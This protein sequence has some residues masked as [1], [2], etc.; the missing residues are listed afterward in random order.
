MALGL[1]GKLR[2]VAGRTVRYKLLILV[3]FPILLLMPVALGVAAI[4]GARFTYDQLFIKVNTD[5]SVAH[6]VFVRLRQ[7]YLHALERLAESYPFRTALEA[8]DGTS[9]H[10]QV[11]ALHEQRHFSYLHVTDR[12]GQ[13]L[14]EAG[15]SGTTRA[16]PLRLAAVQGKPV[17]GVEIF[18]ARDL[19]MESAG[20]AQAVR[21]PLLPTPRARPSRREEED[22]GMMIRMIYPVRDSVGQVTALLDGGVL[23]NGNFEF[24][25]AIRDL[26][27]GPGSLP[28]GSIGTVTVFLDDV[29]ISTNVPLA[30]GERAL[31]TRVSDEVRTQVL[32][33]GTVWI[34]RAFVVND[35]Y[36]SSY[37]PILDV[38]GERIG[39]LY[40]GF[41]E[42]PFRDTMQRALA[43]LALLF[44]VLM[45]LSS[46]VAVRGAKSIFKPLEAMSRVVRETREGH[47]RRIGDVQSRDEIG[48]LAREFDAML[49]LLERRRAQLQEAAD[50]LEHKVAERTAELERTNA[51]QRRTIRLLRETRQQLVMAEKLA[52]LGELTA[53]V[54]HEIN[55]PMAV[56]LGNLDLIRAE[57]GEAAEPVR[58]ELDL[59]IEQVYRIKDIVNRLLQYARPSEFAGFIEAT[60]VNRLARD[61]LE[62]VQHL[63]SGREFEIRLDLHAGVAPR[64]NSQ[65][66]QQV[67]VN[68][69]VNAIHALP[70]RGGVVQL[71]SRDWE[72]KGVVLTVSDNGMGM[73]EDQQSR[74]F[75]PFYSTKG[76]GE[77]TGLGLS[78]SY[79][80]VR[81][82]G[83]NITVS[84]TPGKGSEFRV[85]LLTEPVLTGDEETIAEQLR[86]IEAGAGGN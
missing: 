34:D 27:Y 67:L 70:A 32:D 62:L 18:S 13:W 83:G 28:K 45:L 1:I 16:S 46:V 29:R 5:L 49:D 85:W 74:I 53:G 43:A 63:R 21:L 66:L 15:R 7:D 84:S 73:D 9:L 52:A 44:L 3:L 64:I 65:D 8:R 19:R 31:G 40:A 51:A 72:D 38:S 86:A 57:L 37:E 69:L 23:L 17:S 60:D 56:M 30:P 35:W 39:M 48:V 24:V 20:L 22:R 77:G 76:Q 26:V 33:A 68:L 79:G 80:L 59:I 50:R 71:A 25:D 54:A 81:R 10:R 41:L 42:R 4:W 75:S 47:G 14:Y 61:T 78:V 12:G 6:D 58:R 36:I 11:S 2:Q 82:Y 55:N